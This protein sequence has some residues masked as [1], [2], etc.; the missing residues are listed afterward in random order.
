MDA[1]EAQKII[2]KYTVKD[3]T[4]N[5]PNP[6]KTDKDLEAVLSALKITSPQLF[7]MLNSTITFLDMM[8]GVGHDYS[9]AKYRLELGAL[10]EKE[11]NVLA[12]FLK[13]NLPKSAE[14]YG[15]AVMRMVMAE[16]IRKPQDVDIQLHNKN[17]K[18]AEE[19]AQQA[20]EA[21][22]KLSLFNKRFFV[23]YHDPRICLLPAQRKSVVRIKNVN[24]PVL[25]IHIEGE[26]G[27][28]PDMVFGYKRLPPQLIEGMK[29]QSVMQEQ[30]DKMASSMTQGLNHYRNAGQR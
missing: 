11:N 28:I 19:L 25:D 4:I 9:K 10:S 2:D 20:C 23:D 8:K 12:E 6:I 15:S 29:C 24:T 21:L 27:S 14:T 22:N 18:Q 1:Q 17:G 3:N 13:N 30:I 7:Q 26:E 16:K 5:L